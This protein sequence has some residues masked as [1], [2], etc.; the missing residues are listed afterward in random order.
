MRYA[1]GAPALERNLY[2]LY[3]CVAMLS[4]GYSVLIRFGYFYEIGLAFLLPR[5]ASS[6][7]AS[8]WERFFLPAGIIA[9]ALAKLVR[10]LLLNGGGNG[11]FLPY[12]TIFG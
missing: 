8:R 7:R 1:S 6:P 4:I 2:F 12:R 9:Y 5:I 10:W 3:S 11:G